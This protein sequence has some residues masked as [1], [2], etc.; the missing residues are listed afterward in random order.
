MQTYKLQKY[1]LR[2]TVMSALYFFSFS[3]IMPGVLAFSS[4]DLFYYTWETSIQ[5]NYQIAY[6]S[7]LGKKSIF[8]FKDLE[9]ICT[10]G[11]LYEEIM[12]GQCS[13]HWV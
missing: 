7:Y 2:D 11:I 13:V 10:V 6:L 8:F 12:D 3:C 1:R 5:S 9:I 4:D